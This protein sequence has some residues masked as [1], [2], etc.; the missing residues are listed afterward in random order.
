[1][2][3]LQFEQSFRD[4]QNHTTLKQR[5]NPYRQLISFRDLQNHTTLKLFNAR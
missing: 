1:M 4:L 5:L 3:L 2:G